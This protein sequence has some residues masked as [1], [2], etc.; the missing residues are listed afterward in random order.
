MRNLRNTLIYHAT[1]TD[2]IFQDPLPGL[3]ATHNPSFISDFGGQPTEATLKND[4]TLSSNYLRASQTW[5]IWQRISGKDRCTV[6]T[7]LICQPSGKATCGEK[8]TAPEHLPSFAAVSIVIDSCELDL[9]YFRILHACDGVQTHSF[10]V[11]VSFILLLSDI[12]ILEKASEDL[13]IRYSCFPFVIT[14]VS[15]RL[16]V[17]GTQRKKF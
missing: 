8:I 15:F 14:L 10:Q 11:F 13:R 16:S 5:K 3:S 6:N 1:V 9:I 2:K 12:I 4:L 17:G 7:F